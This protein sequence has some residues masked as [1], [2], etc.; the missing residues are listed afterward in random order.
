[1]STVTSGPCCQFCGTTVGQFSLTS[2][3]GSGNSCIDCD[4]KPPRPV[5]T[6]ETPVDTTA[7]RLAARIAKLQSKAKQLGIDLDKPP[8]SRKPSKP[9][10]TPADKPPSARQNA[11]TK[12][13]PVAWRKIGDHWQTRERLN[14]AIRVETRC[15]AGLVAECL[16]DDWKRETLVDAERVY[17]V[18]KDGAKIRFMKSW[19]G[20]R[21]ELHPVDCHLRRDVELPQ[22]ITVAANRSPAS[23][24]RDITNR[25][26]NNGL[27]EGHKQWKENQQSSQAG[28]VAKRCDMLCVARAMGQRRLAHQRNWKSASY[29][30]TQR[31]ENGVV[32]MHASQSYMDRFEFEIEVTRPEIAEKIAVFVAG[33]E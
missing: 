12:R 11:A 16:G 9:V 14:A 27:C 5:E 23:M 7:D 13:L 29:P 6:E 4:S 26:I 28:D 17:L 31:L 22:E 2:P 20:D 19:H 15:A 25:L 33:L 1:M 3:H 32:R 8:R 21:Y 18:H 30:E 10:A 24:P